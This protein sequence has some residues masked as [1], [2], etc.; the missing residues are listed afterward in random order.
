M[1]YEKAKAAI[2]RRIEG[3]EVDFKRSEYWDALKNLQ[4]RA[5]PIKASTMVSTQA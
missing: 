5:T 1:L 2:E 4:S 3:K